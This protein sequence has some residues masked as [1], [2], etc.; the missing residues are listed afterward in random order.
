MCNVRYNPNER[1][2][3]MDREY[4]E[5]VEYLGELHKNGEDWGN[6]DV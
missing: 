2:A 6:D 5:T 1:R 3:E 4:K